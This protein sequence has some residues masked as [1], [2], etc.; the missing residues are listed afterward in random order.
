MIVSSDSLFIAVGKLISQRK[1][2]C[3]TPAGHKKRMLFKDSFIL[4][5]LVILLIRYKWML[6][7]SLQ[8]VPVHQI[9]K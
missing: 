7:Q 5:S 2:C 1:I 9:S 3:R 6:S 4:F 8:S